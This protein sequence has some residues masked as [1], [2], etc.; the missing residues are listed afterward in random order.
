[1]KSSK[2]M[3]RFFLLFL[4]NNLIVTNSG[5]F[6]DW[7][8]DSFDLVDADLSG[9][10]ADTLLFDDH[11]DL[12]SGIDVFDNDPE[13]DMNAFSLNDVDL[14]NPNNNISPGLAIAT[15]TFYDCPAPPTRMH[16]RENSCAD[17]DTS[18]G[19]T[20]Q[21]R[22]VITTS[23][24]VEEYWCSASGKIGFGN[25]PVCDQSQRAIMPIVI[26]SELDLKANVIPPPSSPPSGFKN[27]GWCSVR[28][29]MH[30]TLGDG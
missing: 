13:S 2:N 19:A 12:E 3:W 29:F 26:P 15:D 30:E 4:G 14:S 6:T 17:P 23:D 11:S 20:A 28:K 21:Q 18:Q 24:Q 7:N 10:N 1:M 16:A 9:L 25:I 5:F 8:L 27:L 22:P